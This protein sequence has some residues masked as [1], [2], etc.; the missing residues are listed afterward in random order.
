M[1][2]MPKG[3][4]DYRKML[5]DMRATASDD[6]AKRKQRMTDVAVKKSRARKPKSE[7]PPGKGTEGNK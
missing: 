4:S 6:E 7:M 3:S 5:D 1:P 2:E